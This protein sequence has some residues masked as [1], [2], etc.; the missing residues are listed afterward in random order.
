M[1]GRPVR[2]TT[3]HRPV[4][5]GRHRVGPADPTGAPSGRHGRDRG[6]AT[7]GRDGPNRRHRDRRRASDPRLPANPAL[8]DHHHRR[9]PV[10]GQ[11][12]GRAGGTRPDHGRRAGDPHP[13][14]SG[15]STT[16]APPHSASRWSPKRSTGYGDGGNWIEL[17][18]FDGTSIDIIDELSD[19]E[20][21]CDLVADLDPTGAQLV[22]TQRRPYVSGQTDAEFEHDG[23]RSPKRVRA[24]AHRFLA[25][26]RHERDLARH[27]RWP[28]RGRDRFADVAGRGHPSRCYA[29]AIEA[30]GWSSSSS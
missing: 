23:R 30:R 16:I 8:H 18:G 1:E 15:G 11:P 9:E 21:S 12:S 6:R 2:R 4:D 10:V 24:D 28:H 19:C 3:E 26:R 29:G 27:R 7:P 14:R 22:Y 5:V 17:L 25:P 20:F 13:G